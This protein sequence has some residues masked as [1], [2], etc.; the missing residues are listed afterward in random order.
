MN[1]I[2]SQTIRTSELQSLVDGTLFYEHVMDELEEEKPIYKK[3]GTLQP[4]KEYPE[5]DI[6]VEPMTCGAFGEVPGEQMRLGWM[7]DDEKDWRVIPPEDIT[8]MIGWLM[9]SSQ[10]LILN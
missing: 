10:Y 2:N 7:S 3:M 8:K 4:H 5:G 6:V 1:P 9:A